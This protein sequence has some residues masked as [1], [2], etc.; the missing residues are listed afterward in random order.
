MLYYYPLIVQLAACL[1][2]YGLGSKKKKIKI[3]SHTVCVVFFKG[4]DSVL[5]KNH[6]CFSQAVLVIRQCV[7]VVLE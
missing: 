5:Y 1:H 4:T 7:G 2:I 3:C 6:L